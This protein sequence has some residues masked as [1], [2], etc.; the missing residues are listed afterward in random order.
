MGAV[1]RATRLKSKLVPGGERIFQRIYTR[2]GCQGRPPYFVV[3][4]H[5]YTGLT[6][7]VRL[8]E[9]TAYVRLS[10]AL[11]DAPTPVFEA[12]AAILLGRLYRRTPP[13]DLLE[14]IVFFVRRAPRA[15][16]CIAC[17]NIERVP[18]TTRPPAHTMISRHCSL[19]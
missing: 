5:P 19:A 13:K 4:F 3:E 11:H 12:A 16:G 17:A 7:T 10:D 8:R 6:L 15:R 1:R 18:R 14:I 2:L 9:D